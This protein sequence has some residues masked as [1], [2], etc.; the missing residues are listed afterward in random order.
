MTH[1]EAP[2]FELRGSQV[3]ALLFIPKTNDL[4]VIRAELTQ[5]FE[6]APD[7]FSNDAV[8]LDM[9]RL[10]DGQSLSLQELA[11]L[12]KEFGMQPIGVV[13]HA[14]QQVWMQESGLTILENHERRVERSGKVLDTAEEEQTV[15]HTEAETFSADNQA[16]PANV[17]QMATRIDKP[18]RSG[19]R[20][21]APG[22][23][24]VLELVS[25]GA[26][27]I[28]EGNIYVYAPLR[29]RALAGVRGNTEAR[30]FC[31]CLE[32][33]LI[34]VAG[35]Y[36]TTDNPLPDDVLGKPAQIRLIDEKL[37]IEPLRLK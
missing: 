27:I 10:E 13:G 7:F 4:A 29:G 9:R 24:L 12:L 30:I 34:S 22:D 37:V 16:V 25:H 5:R 8:A 32:A 1:K 21:Y 28:A 2:I 17:L 31:T 15:A 19:Q 6:S 14:A 20:V 36:R 33:E 18:L 3:D 35:I 26:E 23:L 11:A